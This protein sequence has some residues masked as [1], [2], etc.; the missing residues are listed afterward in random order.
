ME[1]HLRRREGVW[2]D[3]MDREKREKESHDLGE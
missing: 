1:H 2:I 3:S